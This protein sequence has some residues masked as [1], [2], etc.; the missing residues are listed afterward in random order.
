MIFDWKPM[1]RPYRLRKLIFA[2]L[3][4]IAALFLLV[5]EWLWDVGTRLFRFV[6]AWPP[7]AL[8][9]G[10]IRALRPYPALCLF[11]LPAILLFPI[12]ILALIA[13]ASGHAFSGVCAIIVAKVGGAAAVARLYILTRPTLLTLPWFARWH[14]AFMV[15]KERLIGRLKDTIAYRRTSMA[16]TRMRRGSREL[17][18]RVQQKMRR[19]R[20]ASH[21]SRV[22]RRLLAM[23]RAKRRG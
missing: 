3:I 5:E 15:L 21:P 7:I 20:H 11:V 6:A 2:P 17:M 23:W 8:L 16:L 19:G 4:Y 9:E 14:D 22:L 1:D 10:R 12:K 18:L 13:I